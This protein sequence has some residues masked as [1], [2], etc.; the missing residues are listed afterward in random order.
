VLL[1]NINNLPKLEADQEAIMSRYSV[2]HFPYIFKMQPDPSKAYEKQ[3]N[4]RLKEDPEFIRKNILSALLNRLIFEYQRIFDEGIDYSINA[5]LMTEIKENSNHLSQFINEM[6]LK[7]C[8]SINGITTDYLHKEYLNWCLEAN[9]IE[10]DMNDKDFHIKGINGI[11]KYHDPGSGDKI[12]RNSR[13]MGRRLR[14]MF[15]NVQGSRTSSQRLLGV[16]FFS[17]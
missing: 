1:F 2:I 11:K 12:V 6:K 3:A 8:D 10:C 13:E 15:P 16:N 5:E 7:E 9:Y 17:D 4:P 14:E